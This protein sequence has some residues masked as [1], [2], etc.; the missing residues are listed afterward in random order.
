MNITIVGVSTGGPR[1]LREFFSVMPRLHSSLVLIQHMPRFINNAFC[2]DLGRETPMD[3]H[4]GQQGDRLEPGVVHV[5]PSGFHLVLEQ[6]RQ[7]ALRLGAKV[8]TVCPSV[9]VAMLSLK[10]IAGDHVSG[11]VMTGLGRDGAEGIR[12]INNLDGLT[13]VQNQRTAPI[14]DM[15]Q[16]ALT[17]GA[18]DFEGSPSAICRKLIETFG[19]LD[20]TTPITV[21]TE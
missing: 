1:V 10:P 13:C 11:V 8:N 17:T 9:D 2:R 20:A 14:Y 15:P 7:I 4:L 3:I 21:G 18:V 19:C 5:A 16:A 6:N 12:H